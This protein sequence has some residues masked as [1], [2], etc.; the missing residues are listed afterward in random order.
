MAVIYRVS[1]TVV[2]VDDIDC[3]RESDGR[4]YPIM[5]EITNVS[6]FP[7]AVD[8]FLEVEKKWFLQEWDLS[9]EGLLDK[10]NIDYGKN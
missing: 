6:L 7:D 4:Y 10:L 8:A 2:S 9:V 5:V 3:E 1:D